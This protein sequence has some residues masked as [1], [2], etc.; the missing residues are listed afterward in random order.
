MRILAYVFTI[1]LIVYSLSKVDLTPKIIEK[2]VPYEVV[3]EVIKEVPVEKEVIKEVPVE[4]I[5]EKEKIVEVPKII[6]QDRVVYR[7]RPVD[8]YIDR[9][10]DRPVYVPIPSPQAPQ[11]PGFRISIPPPPMPFRTFNPHRHY[12]R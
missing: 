6:Y 11:T 12:R 7:D 9:P 2:P 1:G 4:K 5:I 8:R 3:K 10:V